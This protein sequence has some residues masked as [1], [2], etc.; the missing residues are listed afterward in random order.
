MNFLCIHRWMYR[1]DTEP[2]A[3]FFKICW[4][5]KTNNSATVVK[6]SLWKLFPRVNSSYMRL[7]TTVN[8]LLP[9]DRQSTEALEGFCGSAWAQ[10]TACTTS[11][12]IKIFLFTSW[13][14]RVLGAFRSWCKLQVVC[15]QENS[16]VST[17]SE[18]KQSTICLLHNF[19]TG[20]RIF[21]QLLC[22][23][24]KLALELKEKHLWC[25]GQKSLGEKLFS[26]IQKAFVT[27]S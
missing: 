12:P 20:V 9:K 4:W 5:R 10:S 8:N 13:S 3:S 6:I 11:L 27:L 2:C 16:L 22:L 21:I 1:C 24:A 17:C 15:Q 7:C 25:A 19:Y 14:L 26:I 23:A 18:P